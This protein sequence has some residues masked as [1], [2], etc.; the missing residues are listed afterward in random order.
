MAITPYEQTG[1]VVGGYSDLDTAI[2]AAVT[3]QLVDG[4]DMTLEADRTHWING[5]LNYL[6]TISNESG[7]DYTT[8]SLTFTLSPS[9]VTFVPGSVKINDMDAAEGSSP[10]EYEI[11]NGKLIV[12]LNT[13]A[14]GD[15]DTIV[16][17][18]VVRTSRRFQEHQQ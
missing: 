9:I 15:P 13:I 6:A 4:L 3:I 14:D 17:Y 8:P 16:E 5:S 10:G 1:D 7:V 18:T 12:H 11:S 2:T